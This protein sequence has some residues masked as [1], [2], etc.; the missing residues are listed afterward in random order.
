MLVIMTLLYV[1][2]FSKDF[3]YNLLQFACI[4]QALFLKIG[5]GGGIGKITSF[6]CSNGGS[7]WTINNNNGGSEYRT[8][9]QQRGDILDINNIVAQNEGNYT[10]NDV[11]SQLIVL[12]K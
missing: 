6:Q 12:G 10:C 5:K 7:D 11:T 2:S 9:I 4:T 8:N 1:L 3:L